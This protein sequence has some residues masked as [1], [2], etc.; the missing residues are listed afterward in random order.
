MKQWPDEQSQALIKRLNA[1]FG[2]S[3]DEWFHSKHESFNVDV[4]NQLNLSGEYH[5]IDFSFNIHLTHGTQEIGDWT[6]NLI[7]KGDVEELVKDIKSTMDEFL[8]N[9]NALVIKSETQAARLSPSN[10]DF[11]FTEHEIGECKYPNL[12][13]IRYAFIAL[14]SYGIHNQW[15]RV[16][17]HR[18]KGL[19]LDKTEKALTSDISK[20]SM[21]PESR[22]F[23]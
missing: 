20:R 23:K 14:R 16:F 3:P 22:V 18:D 12:G 5:R 17:F 7:S 2:V 11:D 13:Y 4:G 19:M 8:L 9:Y 21:D 1:M 10:R 6:F 15:V